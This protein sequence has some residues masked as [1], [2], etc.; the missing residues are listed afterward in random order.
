MSV[1]DDANNGETGTQVSHIAVKIP[2][3]WKTNIQLWFI[4][5]ESNFALAKITND[6]TKYH[7]LISSID[8]ETLTA[9]SDILLTPPPTD[10][11]KALKTRLLAEFSASENEQI[12]RLI[13]EL[14]LGDDKPSHLLRKMRGL[15]GTS[16]KDDF[17]KTLWL[18]RLPA[19]MQAILSISTESLDNLAKMADKISEVRST[20]A[21][22]NVFAVGQAAPATS[23]N[24]QRASPLDEFRALRSEVAA[25]RKQVEWLSRDRSR[26]PSPRYN[27]KQ[28]SFPRGRSRDRNRDCS[29]DRNKDYCYYHAQFGKNAKK[30]RSPC[31]YS[32]NADQENS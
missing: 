32:T 13:S 6:D 11:Y 2:P 23:D 9:V 26:G 7:H 10:K 20:Q 30:C 18:Q 19:E 29:R 22:S 27:G 21:D 31:S 4:Q 3:L 1:N 28:N 16:V 8:P 15:G 12:R 17:L 25:L 5:V 24:I 14:H